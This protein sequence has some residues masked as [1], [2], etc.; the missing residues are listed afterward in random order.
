[1]SKLPGFRRILEQDYPTED[2]KLIAQLGVSLNYGIQALYD[3]LNG[4]LSIVD[5]LDSIVKQITV[6]VDSTGAPQAKT[7]LVKPSSNNFQGLMVIKAVNLVNPNVYP[8]GGIFVSYTETT[9][10]I[11]I[12]NITGLQPD[13]NYLLTIWAVR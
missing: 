3:L 8:L 7:V 4:K 2:Q 5:N 13:T 10:S 1:M 9:D 11:I 12:N 6:K